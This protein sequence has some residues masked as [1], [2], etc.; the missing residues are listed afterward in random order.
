MEYEGSVCHRKRTRTGSGRLM[1]GE[2][3]KRSGIY[4]G[5][6]PG[7]FLPAADCGRLALPT[8]SAEAALELRFTTSC[9]CHERV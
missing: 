9:E 2:T 5:H 8:H 6:P 1:R 7:S 3:V 4:Q